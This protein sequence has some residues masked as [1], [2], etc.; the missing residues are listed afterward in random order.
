[1]NPI[2]TLLKTKT[3]AI[4][5]ERAYVISEFVTE[6]NIERTGTKYQPILPRVVAIKVS[7][8]KGLSDLRDFYKQCWRYKLEKGSFSKC[9]FG[10]LK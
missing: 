10:A 7:H 1:M 9:F 2:N 8:I 3:T 5:S 4:R 6:I